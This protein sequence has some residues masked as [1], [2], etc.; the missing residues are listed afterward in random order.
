[1]DAELRQILQL[2]A[3][4]DEVRGRA[5]VAHDEPLQQELLPFAL[6]VRRLLAAGLEALEMVE[7]DA[8]VRPALAALE[9]QGDAVEH[10]LGA[11]DALLRQLRERQLERARSQRE[12]P[13]ML[14]AGRVRDLEPAQRELARDQADAGMV[15]P[16][17]DAERV[18]AAALDRLLRERVR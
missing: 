5:H 9:R 16:G 17:L 15:D 6:L 7:D 3:D 8:V 18:A 2:A 14:E 10:E 1:S 12:E 11:R 13:R 4:R